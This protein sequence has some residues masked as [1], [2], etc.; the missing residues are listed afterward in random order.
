MTRS[1]RTL[2]RLLWLALVPLMLLLVI[3][4]WSA[5]RSARQALAQPPAQEARP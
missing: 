2:H 1:L 3:L 5:H 4:S